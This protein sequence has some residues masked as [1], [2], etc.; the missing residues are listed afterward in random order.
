MRPDS[1]RLTR[2]HRSLVYATL[3]LLFLSGAVW[4]GLNYFTVAPDDFGSASKSVAMKIHGGAAMAI[5][6]LIGMVLHGHVRFAWRVSRNRI[7]GTIFLGAF[8][9]L[10]LTGYGLYYAGG[11]KLRAWTSW[12]HLTAGL[13][14]PILF[15]MHVWLGKRTRPATQPKHHH[16]PARIDIHRSSLT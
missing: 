11:E 14:L 4:A 6:V 3:A 8:A 15:L 2:A 10:T 5:L 9:L 16:L 1:I 7:N 12:I 13:I